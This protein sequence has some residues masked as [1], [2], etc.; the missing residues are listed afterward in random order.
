MDLN[1]LDIDAFVEVIRDGSE[2]DFTDYSYKSLKRRLAKIL[3]DRDTSLQELLEQMKGNQELLVEISLDCTVNTTELF[4]DPPVWKKLRFD[5]LPIYH[6]A[7][8]IKIWHA[9][10]STGQEVY[11]LL[12][13]LHELGLL[14]RSESTGT[15]LNP[16]ALNNAREGCYKYRYN[17]NYLDNFDTV[18][19][20]DPEHPTSLLD[21]PYERYLDINPLKDT[22]RIKPFLLE[23]PVFSKHDLVKGGELEA[24]PF[25]LIFCRNVIIY[26]NYELQ[27]RVLGLLYRQLKT[28]GFL[29]LG[30]HESILGPLAEKFEHRQTIYRKK[31]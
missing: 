1:D 26:F 5:A 16:G 31:R 13:L 29:I 14:E 25:D 11:S 4:R 10:C 30:Q 15:D 28:G 24:G 7:R 17:L 22:L 3:E 21:V 8:E 23:K 9:G 2:Y 18:L 20:E 12:M 19:K 27:N 6:E